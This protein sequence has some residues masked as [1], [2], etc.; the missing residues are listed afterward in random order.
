MPKWRLILKE[1][2]KKSRGKQI[3]CNQKAKKVIVTNTTNNKTLEV[4][5]FKKIS[6]KYI[7]AY[8]NSPGLPVLFYLES[9]EGLIKYELIEITPKQIDRNLF[10]IPSD[11]QKIGFDEFIKLMHSNSQE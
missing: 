7:E 8:K 6:P 4:Y 2:F 3:I 1:S 9:N 10:G 11:Y 5:Y